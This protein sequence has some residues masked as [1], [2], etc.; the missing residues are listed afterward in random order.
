MAYKESMKLRTWLRKNKISQRRF[1]LELGIHWRHLNNL[2][3]GRRNPSA[4]LMLKIENA[5]RG[6][7]TLRDMLDKE[8]LK[9]GVFP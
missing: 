1:A 2:L 8:Q 3:A 4:A 6:E 9:Q 7:V 5:T